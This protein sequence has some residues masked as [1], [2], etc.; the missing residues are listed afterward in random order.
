MCD[1]T[2]CEPSTSH[3]IASVISSSPRGGR[4]D[5]PRRLVDA[6]R[7]HVDADEREVRRRLRRLLDEP[8]HAAA[9]VQ[10]GDAVVLRIGDPR[11]QDQ[12]LGLV[13]PERRHEILDPAL[14]QVV[15]EVHDERIA[16][17]E[18][19]GG[20]HRVRQ[21][22]RRVLLDVGDLDPEALAVARRLADL[23]A[24]LRRDDDPDLADARGR[25]RLDA[26][27]QHRLVGDGDELLRRRVG[28]R[29]QARALA[30][31]ED[32]AFEL[33][34]GGVTLVHASSSTAHRRRMQRSSLPRFARH[35][36]LAAVAR[37]LVVRVRR[38]GPTGSGGAG[39]RRTCVV[40]RTRVPACGDPR[41]PFHGSRTAARRAS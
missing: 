22:E 14:Q 15:A 32:Q 11:E 33:L 40:V 3:W 31:R 21:A 9:V 38:A 10:F 41:K 12:R 29:A 36:C 8:Q 37:I 6:R 25:H 18:R 19:L 35:R 1:S 13:A 27:E 23:A 2:A 28:D 26:V 24:G 5:R 16:A 30:A 4:L 20:E 7:E 34:H 17:Q 39:A